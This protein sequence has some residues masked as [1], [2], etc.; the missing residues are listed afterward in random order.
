MNNKKNKIIIEIEKLKERRKL[1]RVSILK[2]MKER[3]QR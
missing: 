2:K 3:N 1:K